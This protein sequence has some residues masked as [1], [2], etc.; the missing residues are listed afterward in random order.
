VGNSVAGLLQSLIDT[1]RRRNP[2]G[3][4]EL[5]SSNQDLWNDPLVHQAYLQM[6]LPRR[7]IETSIHDKD[8]AR[9]L[10]DR[11]IAQWQAL[12]EAE[13]YW[14]NDTREQHK[15]E[16]INPDVIDAFYGDG[17]N[18]MKTLAAFESRSGVAI[19]NGVCLEL[20]CGAGKYTEALARRFQHV[21]AVDVSAGGLAVCAARAKQLGLTNIE[22]VLLTSVDDLSKFG[23]LDFFLS[24]STL[25]HNPPPVQK[26]L[27][28]HALARVV[29]DGFCLFQTP[30]WLEGY[31]FSSDRFLNDA[32]DAMC[33]CHCLPKTVVLDILA[34]NRMRLLD[35]APDFTVECFGSYTFFARKTLSAPL[36]S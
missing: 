1:M 20:G 9:R 21:I 27:L 14:S 2:K 6:G 11:V 13:P 26:I 4:I 29:P 18:W 16:N 17:H 32:P 3:K 10:M 33:D 12:G 34:A 23:P 28:D 24:L 22:T 15:R 8:L 30:D 5:A 7:A 36:G 31:T 19:K 25:Q 35:F